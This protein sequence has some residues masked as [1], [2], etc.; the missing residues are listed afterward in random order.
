MIL[1]IKSS[2]DCDTIYLQIK[3][4]GHDIVSI[5]DILRARHLIN[6]RSFSLGLIQLES[7]KDTFIERMIKELLYKRTNMEW[8]ALVSSTH[9]KDTH[10]CQLI[11]EHFYDYHTLP[12]DLNRLLITLG[13]ALG[14]A[15]MRKKLF[16]RHS[17][18][19]RK[20]DEIIG[21]STAMDQVFHSMDK[22]ARVDMPV[23]ITGESGTG[24]ELAALAIHKRSARSMGP[25]IAV[26]CGAFPANLIQSELFGYEKWAFTGANQRKIGLI[27]R[28]AGGIIFLD[29]IADLP[30]ELQVNLLRFLQKKTN[31]SYW[32]TRRNP[33]RCS[34]HCRYQR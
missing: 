6:D 1:Y 27:E 16:Q 13:H 19:F 18:N 34:S 2:C 31:S 11:A 25:F 8:L 17:Q 24:K 33:N 10:V 4:A 23:I 29:E 22:I 14:I 26:N 30:L 7:F 3:S 21:S 5:S 15:E 28:A 20:Y 9:M 32:W 12:V